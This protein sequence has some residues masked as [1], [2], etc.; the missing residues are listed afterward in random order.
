[1]VG[2]TTLLE[3]EEDAVHDLVVAQEEKAGEDEA[4]ALE[5]GREPF[6]DLVQQ[7]VA[8]VQHLHTS[9][10]IERCTGPGTHQQ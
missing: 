10:G 6:L 3:L 7:L 5:V 4:L 2:V 9:T 1:M 8:L